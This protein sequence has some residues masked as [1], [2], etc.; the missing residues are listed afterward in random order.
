MNKVVIIDDLDEFIED[1]LNE[2]NIEN[3]ERNENEVYETKDNDV[4][5][6]PESEE[7]PTI[8]S[9]AAITGLTNEERQEIAKNLSTSKRMN[10]TTQTKSS[11]LTFADQAAEITKTVTRAVGGFMGVVESGIQLAL[12][13][14]ETAA[15]TTEGWL[16][17]LANFLGENGFD[18]SIGGSTITSAL[19]MTAKLGGTLVNVMKLIA[20]NIMTDYKD[21]VSETS[22]GNLQEQSWYGGVNS[23]L[24]YFKSN[25]EKVNFLSTTPLDPGSKREAL[26]GSI[27][28]GTPYTFNSY[29]DPTNRTFIN[30]LVKD[31]KYVSFTPG[32]PK[33]NGLSYTSGTEKNVLNQTET[34]ESM[35]AYLKK[36]GLDEDFSNKDKRYYTFKADY[37]AYF[38]YLET[39]LNTLWVKMGL[40]AN[41]NQFDLFTFFEIDKNNDASNYNTLKSQYKSPISFYTNA[42]NSVN[43]SVDSSETSFGSE[44]TSDANGKS[45]AY[46]R[47]NYITGM[48]TSDVLNASRRVGII[49]QQYLDL[50]DTTGTI[51]SRT[52]NAI[53]NAMQNKKRIISN[54]AKIGVAMA[55]DTITFG[56]MQDAGAVIQQFAV[57]NGMTV[58]YP[59]L[60]SES[61]Y[62]KSINLNFSFVSPYGDPLSIFKYVYVPFCCLLCFALPRQAAENGLVS[63][64][65]IRADIPGIGTSD[66][67]L[68][69]NLS[70]TKSIFTKDNLPR[71]IDCTLGI[72]DLYHYLAMSKRIS[73]LSANPSYAVFLDSLSGMLSTT[74]ST[75]DALNAYF[76]AM[77][78]RV[79]NERK[80]TGMWNK[81]NSTKSTLIKQLSEET[82][83][84]LSAT[85]DLNDIPWL[86]NS[87]L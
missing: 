10:Q 23:F 39:M 18:D 46:Q 60:W 87:S 24:N 51:F 68:I 30:S 52:G 37:P 13:Y 84:S 41:G 75:D 67:A 73:F 69:N 11:S 59:E 82:R 53:S 26:F 54:I 28:L 3:K 17:S 8:T 76:E 16:N 85:V 66:L 6:T 65:L 81:F 71:R 50:K 49:Q 44:L 34:P 80:S 45:A 36:N 33:Y 42:T 21:G 20:N 86:H 38:S 2:D 35:L 56:S 83:R 27:V 25:T 7:I 31:G 48:G 43:E 78:N 72:S 62:S 47:L 77:V 79:N 58:R 63:P 55:T 61:N 15:N 74:D 40:S 64:F 70:W 1:L 14:A 57:S 4:Q 32:F 5:T 9:G 19:K 29:S 12:G 22:F